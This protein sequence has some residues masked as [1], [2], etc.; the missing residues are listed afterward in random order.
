MEGLHSKWGIKMRKVGQVLVLMV[1]FFFFLSS[2]F[3]GRGKQVEEVGLKSPYPSPTVRGKK[4]PPYRY[5]EDPTIRL[6]KRKYIPPSVWDVAGSPNLAKERIYFKKAIE[7]DPKNPE[8]LY[9][10]AFNY[11]EDRKL[12]DSAKTFEKVLTLNPPLKYH[13]LALENLALVYMQM[14]KYRKA[15]EVA[16][17]GLKYYPNNPRLI[18]IVGQVYLHGQKDPQKAMDVYRKAISDGIKSPHIYTGLADVLAEE[19]RED[20]AIPLLERCIREFRGYPNA[21]LLLADIY[22]EK[23]KPFKSI[24]LIRGVI[25]VSP[26]FNDAFRLLSEVYIYCGK[27]SEAEKAIKKAISFR[28][29]EICEFKNI[30]AKIYILQG[31]Y[32]K[33]LQVLKEVLSK[34]NTKEDKDLAQVEMALAYFKKGEVKKSLQILQKSSESPL[35]E[36]VYSL[37]Y[38]QRKEYRRALKTMEEVSRETAMPRFLVYQQMAQ[39]GKDMG[40]EKVYQKYIK[41]AMEEKKKCNI[42]PIPLPL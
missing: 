27:Y 28:P 40:D 8:P 9:F 2:C 30:L 29:D 20:E 33:A 35:R 16:K 25:E 37:I 10:L 15:M 32:D 17:R 26:S 19:G 1:L 34:A 38:W 21:S 12:Q 23:G 31:E 42:E 24:D 41:K 14:E 4:V 13:R 11:L 36:Y 39:I 5:G 3:S 6:A 22:L 7:R 18:Y